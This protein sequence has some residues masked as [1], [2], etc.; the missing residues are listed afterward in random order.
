MA[1]RL[2]H[3]EDDPN[4]RELV[5]EMLR[6]DGVQCVITPVA[7][8]SEF[9]RELADVP[10]LILAD[11]SLP[12]FD[13]VLAQELAQQQCPD[14]PFVFVSGSFGEDVAVERLKAGATDYVLKQRLERLP[15]A[16]YRA[17]QEARNRRAK[18]FLEQLI[19]SSPS[20]IFRLDVHDQRVTYVSP[21]VAWLLGYSVEEILHTPAF[22][23]FLAHPDD[24]GRIAAA[25]QSART[26]E[27]TG[28]IEDEYR[29]RRKDG[30]YRWFYNLIRIEYDKDAR[31]QSIV[32]YA[33]DIADR[34]A[35]Q[36]ALE[37]AR[38]EAVA[39][40]HDAE[41][42]N[43]AKSDFLSR[44]SHDLR[45]PLNSILGFAQVLELDPLG[46]EQAENVAQI[47]SGGK[48]LLDLINEV[49]DIAR[50]E[51]GHLSLSP[52]P[53]SLPE[54]VHHCLDIVRPLATQ[55]GITFI[56][57]EGRSGP[58]FARADRQRL[59][60]ILINLLSNAVKYNREHGT[61]RVSC[62][63]VDD[64]TVTVQV[65]D[66]GAGVPPEKIALLFKPFERLGAEQTGVEGTG[67]GLALSKALAEA[68][69][70][71]LR[72]SSI[73]DRGSTFT[74]VL[75]S[76]TAARVAD[77]TEADTAVA[78]DP[79]RS[80]TL[81]YVEDNLQNVR[82]MQR[83]VARRPGVQL[84]HAADGAQGLA[85]IRQHR[86][87]LV[88]LDLHL[89]DMHGEEVLRQVWEDPATRSTAVAVLTAD[90]TP[91]QRRRLLAAGASSY[92]TKPLDIS[93]VLKLI[94]E[95]LGGEVSA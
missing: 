18:D 85:Y 95:V 88:F 46:P 77:A 11:F 83:L 35:A 41:R 81:L 10:D 23:D 1:L 76:A 71:Q 78:A 75:P 32:G 33:L 53:V 8:R 40:R 34:K 51:A 13:G 17:I 91:S 79:A 72:A 84:V 45:T 25:I 66:T 52:E 20:M 80:G 12:G 50:I 39:A 47:L 67:L 54:V 22:W 28:Q 21:N 62:A 49:L 90:A 58:P 63:G 61:V 68:M 59:R 44:M 3:L 24:R 19:A 82:L 30:Q 64:G 65:V 36:Q 48:H 87:R 14:V 43:Q 15:A 29:F 2:L 60:Q 31:P 6:A 89:P 7:S 9:V 73:M 93:E 42:A 92:I 37:H 38:Q 26:T 94:D 69:G 86:P 70:G 55:R 74:V 4:D 5:A 57:N 16:V 27:P 56:A